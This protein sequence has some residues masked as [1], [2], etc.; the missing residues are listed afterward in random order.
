M[1]YRAYILSLI[2]YDRDWEAT[3]ASAAAAQIA[4]DRAGYFRSRS[5]INLL[6]LD[7]VAVLEEVPDRT[8]VKA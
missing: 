2:K 8:S 3:F 6:R 4:I 1:K 5:R 7:Y